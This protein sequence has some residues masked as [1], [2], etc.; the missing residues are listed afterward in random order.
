MALNDSKYAV[1]YETTDPSVAS[2]YADTG[3]ATRRDGFYLSNGA[4]RNKRSQK[5]SATNVGSA[6]EAINLSALQEGNDRIHPGFRLLIHDV[7]TCPL[8]DSHPLKI[9]G[10]SNPVYM[11]GACG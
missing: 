5:A 10:Y 4:A 11:E 7:D 3:S 8:R 2:G 1:S 9:I 6:H